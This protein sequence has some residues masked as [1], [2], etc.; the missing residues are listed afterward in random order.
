V[1]Q[2]TN[3]RAGQRYI[4]RVFKRKA[5]ICLSTRSKY[6]IFEADDENVRLKRQTRKSSLNIDQTPNQCD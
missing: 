4:P 2:V 1:H 3:E 5:N 6:E